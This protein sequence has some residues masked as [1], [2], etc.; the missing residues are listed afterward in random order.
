MDVGIVALWEHKAS[1]TWTV[2]SEA[3]L[4]LWLFPRDSATCISQPKLA[5]VFFVAVSAQLH[6][7]HVTCVW[8]ACCAQT[9]Q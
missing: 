7:R 9:A 5:P 2:V 6:D 1:P 4:E 8:P 3:T